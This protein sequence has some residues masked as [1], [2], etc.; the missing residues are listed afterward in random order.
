MFK[1]TVGKGSP[2]LPK[3]GGFL[4]EVTAAESVREVFVNGP[5]QASVQAPKLPRGARSVGSRDLT[6]RDDNRHI[7]G[8]GDVLTGLQQQSCLG[9][10]SSCNYSSFLPC[11]A[12]RPQWPFSAEMCSECSLMFQTWAEIKETLVPLLF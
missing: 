3:A 6:S 10:R 1:G 12:A 11:Q 5:A 4:C 9:A 8:Q 2:C 7:P